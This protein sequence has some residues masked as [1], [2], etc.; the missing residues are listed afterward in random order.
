[1][2]RLR[3]NAFA[4]RPELAGLLVA[5]AIMAGCGTNPGSSST[6]APPPTSQPTVATDTAFAAWTERQGFGGAQGSRT[7]TS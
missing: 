4:P 6:A 1:M 5:A 7:W 2:N 3:L